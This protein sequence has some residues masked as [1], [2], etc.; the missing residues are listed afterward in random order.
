MNAIGIDLDGSSRR[1]CALD[2]HIGSRVRLRRTMMFMTQERLGAALGCSFQ[3]VQKYERGLSRIG[4]ARLFRLS[5]ILQVPITYFFEE[6][7]EALGGPGADAEPDP[8]SRALER[9]M[10]QRET[11]ELVD[12]YYSIKDV[13]LRSRILSFIE[14]FSRPGEPP[15]LGL[16][17]PQG[18]RN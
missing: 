5:Q 3:Q 16:G 18:H 2:A 13:R 12:A 17:E 14:S 11:M 4:A 7:P 15:A 8:A 6:L 1:P 10:G 9:H